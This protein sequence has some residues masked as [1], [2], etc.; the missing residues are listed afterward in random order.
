MSGALDAFGPEPLDTFDTSRMN[1]LKE[2]AKLEYE[3]C[4]LFLV[5]LQ[6]EPP[7]ASAIFYNIAAARTRHV[8]I[9][10]LLEIRHAETFTKAWPQL[11]RWLRASDAERNHIV[12]WGQDE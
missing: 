5:L 9:G 6:T 8:I 12:H 10:S 7:V 2:H 11:E 4:R 1:A 3:V